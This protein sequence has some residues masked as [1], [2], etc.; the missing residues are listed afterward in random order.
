MHKR[1]APLT[2]LDQ[3]DIWQNQVHLEEAFEP[4]LVFSWQL[5]VVV[6]AL[7]YQWSY[8]T[9]SRVSTAGILI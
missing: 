6:T 7:G 1:F 5:D 8:S 4:V 2:A 3:G 9:L